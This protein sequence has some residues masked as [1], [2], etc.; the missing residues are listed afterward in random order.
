VNIVL[1]REWKEWVI[2]HIEETLY[3]PGIVSKYFR[4][5]QKT[6]LRIAGL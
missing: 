5:S 1:D 3:I 4:K 2:P 6:L